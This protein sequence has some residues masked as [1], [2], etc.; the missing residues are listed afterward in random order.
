MPRTNHSCKYQLSATGGTE[1]YHATSA[2]RFWKLTVLRGTVRQKKERDHEYLGQ[3]VFQQATQRPSNSTVADKKQG[4]HRHRDQELSPLRN[5]LSNF[6]C[7][8]FC[9]RGA[10]KEATNQRAFG[11]DVQ[12]GIRGSRGDEEVDGKMQSVDV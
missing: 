2:D 12:Y 3:V 10:G 11:A 6:S 9:H 4:G 5:L 7:K 8:R 1:A